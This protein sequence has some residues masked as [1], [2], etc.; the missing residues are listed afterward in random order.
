MT[1]KELLNSVDF[2]NVARQI[3]R[4]YPGSEHSL[5]WY[6]LHF[7]MLRLMTPKVHDDANDTVCH[8]TMKDWCDGTGAHLDAYPMEGDFWEHSLT[9]ELILAPDI[10]VSNEE[11]AACC[12]WHTSFYGFVEEQVDET[13][14]E[15][16]EE[17]MKGVVDSI[18]SYGGYVPSVKELATIG[19]KW[20]R[21]TFFPVR[22][23]SN[24]KR[25][26]YYR[27]ALR[28]WYN[29]RTKHVG[30]FIA[31]IIPALEL[32]TNKVSATALCQLFYSDSV[33][34]TALPSFADEGVDSARYLCE[35]VE[36]YDIL[37]EADNVLVYMARG[38]D[39]DVLCETEQQLY[40]TICRKVCKSNSDAGKALIVDVKPE[41]GRQLL[42]RIASY[43]GKP[44]NSQ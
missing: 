21:K 20:I 6:K 17:G 5:G 28:Y 12:L 13:F 26:R 34:M 15:K 32:T 40:N 18:C 11:L 23:M 25:K 33:A 14:M 42:L 4:L 3:V 30:H 36:K 27:E 41:L 2:D 22:R 16:D 35:W 31:S 1:Y 38:N 7:D 9:K 39:S 19:G 29:R 37:Q 10:K 43:D 44:I 8:I 24:I